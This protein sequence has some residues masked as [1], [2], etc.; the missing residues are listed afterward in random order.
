[1]V[2]SL[3]EDRPTCRPRLG[4]VLER[5]A[6][7]IEYFA[8]AA[9]VGRPKPRIERHDNRSEVPLQSSHRRRRLEP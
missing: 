9:P 1:M 4:E 8:C 5:L 7:R 6:A 3:V 2:H